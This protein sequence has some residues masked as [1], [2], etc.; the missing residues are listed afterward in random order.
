MCFVK[1]GP[2]IFDYMYPRMLLII[3]K[4]SREGLYSWLECSY[5]LQLTHIPSTVCLPGG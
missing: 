3:C 5:F 4:P 1:H 2:H